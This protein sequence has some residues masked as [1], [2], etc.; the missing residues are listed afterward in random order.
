MGKAK[1]GELI[2]D[3]S[4]ELNLR[5][6]PIEVW[7]GVIFFCPQMGPPTTKALKRSDPAFH[8]EAEIRP[9]GL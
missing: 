5:H 7:Q 9:H 8:R 2:W 1:S 3:S 4:S 6:L